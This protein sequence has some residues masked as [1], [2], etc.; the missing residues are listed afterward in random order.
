MDTI[1][2]SHCFDGTLL[3]LTPRTRMSQLGCS[4]TGCPNQR[5]A[6]GFCNSHYAR[7]QRHGNPCAG[8]SVIKHNG[9]CGVVGCNNKYFCKGFCNV[10]Y[11]RM[12]YRK[13]MQGSLELLNVQLSLREPDKI[14]EVIKRRST[15]V[16]SSGCWEWVRNRKR[17]GYGMMW[18]DKKEWLAHRA[19]A[20]VFL[21]LDPNSKLF[22][23]HHC[24][25]PRCVNPSHLFIGT[26]MENTRDMMSKGRFPNQSGENSNNAILT[27]EIVRRIRAMRSERGM[28]WKQIATE[29]KLNQS[30]VANAGLGFNWKE[31]S[32]T[33][34]A[35]RNPTSQ[36]IRKTERKAK[37]KESKTM[38]NREGEGSG[39]GKSRRPLS[40][41]SLRRVL[42]E[43]RGVRRSLSVYTS[44]PPRPEVRAYELGLQLS[45]LQHKR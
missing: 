14:K 7:L 45:V 37:A 30:T 2:S 9:I 43:E 32:K 4:V 42:P 38:G 11:S 1:Q 28:T 40:V 10:H 16:E 35:I 19:S 3:S 23:C 25:N 6:K 22:A 29:L 13:V 8:R 12:N 26:P 24:D 5:H 41:P 36:E 44:K 15:V 20:V 33:Q 18:I 17:T 21:G 39:S 31:S 34:Y 27:W